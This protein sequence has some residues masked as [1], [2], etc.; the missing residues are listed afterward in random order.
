MRPSTAAVCYS[1]I[2]D[3]FVAVADALCFRKAA[4]GL[5]ISHP[6]LCHQ[7]IDLENELGTRLF[8]R[9]QRGVALTETGHTFLAGARKTLKCA[10]QTI[11]TTRQTA[12]IKKGE[13]RITNIGLM[14]PSVLV[15]LIRAFH[16]RFPNVQVSMCYMYYL[17]L[18]GFRKMGFYE[19]RGISI[20]TFLVPPRY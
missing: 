8:K 11:E 7:I 15:R 1:D 18:T 19:E 4:H 16:E 17:S 10:V 6:A 3:I 2:S 9:N 20:G 12:R 14:C 13:L 5:H